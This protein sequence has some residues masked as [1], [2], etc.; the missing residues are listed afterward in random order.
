MKIA[1]AFSQGKVLISGEHSVVYGFVGI[2]C[3]INRGITVDLG[4]SD[5]FVFRSKYQDS[6]GIIEKSLMLMSQTDPLS[7]TVESDLA[8]G[9][10]L[11]SSAALASATIQAL[12]NYKGVK[13]TKDQLFEYV[14]ECERLAH[15]SPSGIDPATVINGGLIQY[16]KG[17]PLVSH[18]LDQEY[19]FLLLQTGKPVE[20]T[21]EM[22]ELVANYISKT[23]KTETIIERIGEVSM[24]ISE[25][26]LQG[27][28]IVDLI[29]QNGW[30]LEKL[31]VVGRRAIRISKEL[32]EL[33]FGVKITG[34]GG[35]A[36]SSG[37]LLVTGDNIART[38]SECRRFDPSAFSVSVGT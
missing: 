19:T 6:T 18:V 15:G 34:A 1:S 5:E 12:A 36:D 28:S 33:G 2:A 8:M 23:P 16:A 3:A 31:G 20:S 14:M 27:E 22:V 38:M 35:I 10:G 29:N 13:L 9:S 25:A 32:R 17:K 21:R 11:G 4:E 26:M 24:E 7:I 37:M 30:L